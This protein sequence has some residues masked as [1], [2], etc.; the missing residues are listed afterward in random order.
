LAEASKARDW[1]LTARQLLGRA[2]DGRRLVGR[3]ILK[4]L[5]PPI[6]RRAARARFELVTELKSAKALGIIPQALLARA[7]E[8]IE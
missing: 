6:Y 5:N 4:L 2:S 3:Q 1:S 8:V 7:D